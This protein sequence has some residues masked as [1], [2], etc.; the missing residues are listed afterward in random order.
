MNEKDNIKALEYINRYC[1]NEYGC[2]A[3]TSNLSAIDIA[4]TT[5]EDESEEIQVAINLCEEKI[6]KYVNRKETTIL[7]YPNHS[8][9]LTELE[10]MTF[11]FLIGI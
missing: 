10:N 2:P 7:S 1:I 8:S 11:D 5:T 3:D 6:I 4:Y 9:F